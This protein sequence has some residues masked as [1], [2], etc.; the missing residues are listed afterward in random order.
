MCLLVP[1]L[2]EIIN[3][4]FDLAYW[5]IFAAALPFLWPVFRFFKA[6]LLSP[7]AAAV[8]MFFA[9]TEHWLDDANEERLKRLEAEI[10]DQKIA[11]A[12]A[13]AKIDEERKFA[14]EWEEA[15]KHNQAAL[16]KIQK[17]IEA[18]DREECAT[19]GEFFDEL[20]KLR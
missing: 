11:L 5:L 17:Q 4:V 14:S 7:A 18:L 3:N 13:N 12:T 1:W 6:A 20:D 16:I 9:L 8:L 15:A 10:R 19:P 2:C